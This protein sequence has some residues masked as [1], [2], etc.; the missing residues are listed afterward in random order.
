MTCIVFYVVVTTS[1]LGPDFSKSEVS[2]RGLMLLE[3]PKLL[4]KT[5]SVLLQ[6]NN[7]FIYI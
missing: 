4:H 3:F 1:F 6:L 2:L 7:L 5:Y